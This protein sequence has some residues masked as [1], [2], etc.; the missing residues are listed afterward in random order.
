MAYN[1]R[2]GRYHSHRQKRE[3]ANFVPLKYQREIYQRY[4]LKTFSLPFDGSR[5]FGADIIDDPVDPLNF[6]NYFI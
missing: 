5:R 1:R 2:S 3:A 4:M 6:V